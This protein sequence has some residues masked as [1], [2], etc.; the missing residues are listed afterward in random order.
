M[1][2][3]A[4]FA[5]VDAAGSNPFFEAVA[6]EGGNPAPWED[7]PAPEALRAEEVLASAVVDLGAALGVAGAA[8]LPEYLRRR[9]FALAG[10]PSGASSGASDSGSDADGG[11][12]AGA[13]TGAAAEAPAVAEIVADAVV[14]G[15]GAGGGVAAAQ[16]AAAGLRVVVLEKAT[17]KR[18]Q[19]ACS[20]LRCA[21]WLRFASPFSFPLPAA[22][23]VPLSSLS[24]S[25]VS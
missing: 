4:I 15:S 18:M 7:K 25:P 23:S 24:A 17:W 9:G 2:I 3:A 5:T 21:A 13:G 19:G 6:Y 14:V 12:G 16:L 1:L 20:S 8:G 11:A 10:A 22:A